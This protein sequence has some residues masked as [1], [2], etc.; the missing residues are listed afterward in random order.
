MVVPDA[1]TQCIR[2]LVLVNTE[3][4]PRELKN[5]YLRGAV[6]LRARGVEDA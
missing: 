6:N 5:V 4:S 1:Q 2:V 3:K